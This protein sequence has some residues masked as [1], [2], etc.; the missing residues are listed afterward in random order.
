MIKG[1]KI[2]KEYSLKDIRELALE[3]HD[4]LRAIKVT[5]K[6]KPLFI[7]GILIALQNEDFANDYSS[8]TSYNTVINN[9][10]LAIDSVLSEDDISKA[11][12]N[13]VKNAFKTFSKSE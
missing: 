13:Y 11:K 2:Q 7:A 4:S 8:F 3:M 6:H 1:E 10:N 5:E 9:L 12:I